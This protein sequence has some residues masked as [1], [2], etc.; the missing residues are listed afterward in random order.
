MPP[1]RR[2]KQAA[3]KPRAKAAAACRKALPTSKSAR[4]ARGR[5]AAVKSASGKCK[6]ASTPVSKPHSPSRP[7]SR[8]SR[9]TSRSKS[10]SSRRTLK[11]EC[12]LAEERID[13]CGR[14]ARRSSSAT[15]PPAVLSDVEEEDASSDGD[16]ALLHSS[17]SE[18]ANDAATKVDQGSD[19]MAACLSTPSK[20]GAAERRAHKPPLPQQ[21]KSGGEDETKR[22]EDDSRSRE[23]SP[24]ELTA[25]SEG[26]RSSHRWQHHILAS[27]ASA[28]Q[29]L[30]EEDAVEG[31]AAVK[32]LFA[33]PQRSI[34]YSPLSAHAFS[35][36][37]TS[38]SSS[39]VFVGDEAA[40]RTLPMGSEEAGP[41]GRRRSTSTAQHTSPRDE[42]VHRSSLPSSLDSSAL[43]DPPLPG[44]PTADTPPPSLGLLR[45]SDVVVATP[46]P[47]GTE[48]D[49]PLHAQHSA[50]VS[51]LGGPATLATVRGW[52]SSPAP[53]PLLD[54]GADSVVGDAGRAG[55]HPAKDNVWDQ[56]APQEAQSDVSPSPQPKAEGVAVTDGTNVTPGL[57]PP[58]FTDVSSRPPAQQHTSSSAGGHLRM[59]GSASRA[60]SPSASTARLS[61]GWIKRVNAGVEAPPSNTTASPQERASH[62]PAV[63]ATESCFP[64][65]PLP[66]HQQPRYPHSRSPYSTPPTA[67]PPNAQECEGER[68]NSSSVGHSGSSSP[69]RWRP[70]EPPAWRSPQPT[71]FPKS[72]S[73]SPSSVHPCAVQNHGSSYCSREGELL[74]S[75]PS[76]SQTTVLSALTTSPHLAAAPASALVQ[77]ERSCSNSSAST[78]V[79]T[80]TITQASANA[81]C[82]NA[83][84]QVL[85]APAA[86]PS[87]SAT[88]GFSLSAETGSPSQG[89]A[90][91]RPSTQLITKAAA[92]RPTASPA[93]LWICLDDDDDEEEEEE[94]EGGQEEDRPG[95]E[96]GADEKVVAKQKGD[97]A[98][99]AKTA[100][101]PT[102]GSQRRTQEVDEEERPPRRRLAEKSHPIADILSPTFRP[103]HRATLPLP[104]SSRSEGVDDNENALRVSG[105]PPTSGTTHALSRD[106][107]S[108]FIQ[109]DDVSSSSEERESA[110]DDEAPPRKRSRLS[111]SPSHVSDA[112]AVSTANAMAPSLGASPSSSCRDARNSAPLIIDDD[113]DEDEGA[114]GQRQQRY[115]DNMSGFRDAAATTTMSRTKLPRAQR[116][117][118]QPPSEPRSSQPSSPLKPTVKD[119]FFPK[120]L[121]P[122]VRPSSPLYESI[123]AYQQ[124]YQ[125]RQQQ[126]QRQRQ[127]D[128]KGK[129]SLGR[130]AVSA[131]GAVDETLAPSTAASMPRPSHDRSQARK[132]RHP[133]MQAAVKGST[134]TWNGSP[135]HQRLRTATG[136][137][138]ASLV[139]ALPDW[140][141]PADTLLRD[142]F[143]TKFTK[144]SFMEAAQKVMSPM[145]FLEPNDFWE[146]FTAAEFV[147]EGS[148]GL[149]W[150]CRT[151]DGDL[152]AVKSCPIV[153]RT[154]ANIEDS[155]S[156]I[157]EVATMRFLNE[158]QVPYIL[159]LHSAFFVPTAEALPP[160]A[161]AALVWRQQLHKKAEAAVLEKEAGRLGMGHVAL[162]RRGSARAAA[163]ATDT[164]LTFE[165]Q[166]E[167]ELARQA[168]TET[169]EERAVRA[170]LQGVRLPQFLS[171]TEDDLRQSDATVFLVME[172]CDGDVEG[173]PRSDGVTKGV[174]YCVSSA[175]AAMHELGLLHL[176]VKPSNVLF[177][178]EHGPSQPSSAA[179]AAPSHPSTDAIKFYLSDF[180]NCR[181]LGPDPL[182]EVA[183]SYGTFEYMDLRALQEAVCGRPTDAFSL[184]ATLYALLY[185]QRLYP[186]CRNP[187]CTEEEDH[188]RECFVEAAKRPVVLPATTAS[189]ANSP[190][191]TAAAADPAASAV[192]APSRAREDNVKLSRI[193]GCNQ[194][195][196]STLR[197]NDSTALTP[198]QFLTLSLLH[199]NWAERMTAAACRRYLIDIF[200]IT[201]TNAAEDSEEREMQRRQEP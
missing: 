36:P 133:S 198:L 81:S 91:S 141:R 139:P 99:V 189:V 143:P 142:F 100:G 92:T 6:K 71:H 103:R 111:E 123:H 129:S 22:N 156:A 147:G 113:S 67:C 19:V 80:Q 94:E 4:T 79:L 106:P 58:E 155:F 46:A 201:Q 135:G 38:S 76:A 85:T 47:K 117:P 177:A 82:T 136:D 70:R 31:E 151:V 89:M 20:A 10:A 150:R 98:T 131:G 39:R 75:F 166:V 110:E 52:P 159:P 27:A 192:T 50:D 101:A 128:T 24:E 96:A 112:H 55:D 134:A 130:T 78:T 119:L 173:I 74:S 61:F 12:E 8:K 185:G 120:R 157:R 187:K 126:Q 77:R 190:G 140:G 132:V 158:M 104:T 11:K 199:Q 29:L 16:V 93:T 180:G 145:H 200:H 102:G 42:D 178:Y 122:E 124:R 9:V 72:L 184:G 170:R 196:G 182:A 5:S 121:D 26:R 1:K 34:S 188:T 84:M 116:L 138:K 90:A 56:R 57:H 174:A 172:L 69:L 118:A 54:R 60:C 37:L 21:Q 45:G 109:L 181:L 83:D 41:H 18:L 53:L 68:S 175:L 167:A 15:E 62:V 194:R 148:F 3:A 193:K 176:D 186:K 152:V 127:H 107:R 160:P 168:A 171:I 108:F 191:G 64:L 40:D 195:R 105:A 13:Q 63:L 32:Q 183:E 179:A 163:V 17:S 28:T 59:G 2:V 162:S 48:G 49:A 86:P 23:A 146:A 149:V 115:Q 165:Q 66:L 88:A 30:R 44:S 35:S 97:G 169:H 43:H 95:R 154:K 137:A 87:A 14:D 33:R 25:D 73:V 125:E 51:P 114:E 7:S 144:K 164:P 197:S 153:L 65:L 161:Q